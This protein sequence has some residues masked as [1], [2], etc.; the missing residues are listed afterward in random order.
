MNQEWR[1][2]WWFSVHGPVFWVSF[3]AFTV[4][5]LSLADREG[6]WDAKPYPQKFSSAAS[7]GTKPGNSLNQ[8]H[9][10]NRVTGDIDINKSISNQSKFCDHFNLIIFLRDMQCMKQAAL[11]SSLV[12]IRHPTFAPKITSS[13]GS[14]NP[15]ICL[16]P[17][18]HLTYHP[19]PH[20][21]PISQFAIMYWT[22]RWLIG[23]WRKCS[24]TIESN[25][26]AQ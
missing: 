6:I 4:F 9:W 20:P 17:G 18:S 26:V 24:M 16:I 25:D 19:K 5:L 10:Q 12:T 2:H 7:E 23:G 3:G 22:D 15:T 11:N 8:S 13:R 1:R 14:Q 21:Y